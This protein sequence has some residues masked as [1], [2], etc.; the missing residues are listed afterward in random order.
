MEKKPVI[1]FSRVVYDEAF[2][3]SHN[4]ADNTHP[5]KVTKISGQF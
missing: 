4:Q 5:K 2:G 1:L 3:G